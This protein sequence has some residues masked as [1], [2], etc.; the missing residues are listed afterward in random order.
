MVPIAF[1]LTLVLLTIFF[2]DVRTRRIYLL[3]LAVFYPL[4]MLHSWFSGQSWETLG[5]KTS[6]LAA[7]LLLL[8]IYTRFVK[9]IAFFEGFGLGDLLFFIAILPLFDPATFIFYYITGLLFSLCTA[10]LLLNPARNPAKI[11]LAGLLGIWMI[12]FLFFETQVTAFVNR[13][14]AHYL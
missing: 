8:F 9:K 11:P 12:P 13:A 3:Q 1:V 5:L 7:Q 14:L 4:C 10:L 2:T 6:W